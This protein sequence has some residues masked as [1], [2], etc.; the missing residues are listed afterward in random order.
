MIQQ[1]IDL[2]NEVNCRREH[3]AEGAEHLLYIENKLSEI[4]KHGLSQLEVI[5]EKIRELDWQ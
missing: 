3:G 4:I 5:K 1:L 2:K